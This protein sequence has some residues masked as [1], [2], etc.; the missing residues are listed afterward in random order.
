MKLKGI[1]TFERNAD[2]ILLGVVSVAALGALALQFL[3]GS[4]TIKVGG[5][6]TPLGAAFAPVSA[7]AQDLQVKVNAESPTFPEAPAFSLSDKLA[8]GA[9]APAYTPRRVALGPAPLITRGDTSAAMAASAYALP[10]VPAPS[11][12]LAMAYTATIHPA[13][14]LQNP[15]LGTLLPDVQPFDKP[16]VSIECALD[17]SALRAALESDPEGPAEP[18]P[19]GWWRDPSGLGA[20]LVAIVALEVERELLASPD[21]M[22]PEG[23]TTSMVQ[24]MPGRINGLKLWQDG[25]RSI[26]DVPITIDTLRAAAAEVQRPDYYTVIEGPEWESPS[27]ALGRGDPAERLKQV[28]LGRTQFDRAQRQL[29]DMQER[30]AAAPAGDSD[31][32]RERE[33]TGVPGGGKGGSGR[34]PGGP[35][36][37]AA[38]APA[39]GDRRVI[40]RNIAR[41]RAELDAA[42]RKLIALGEEVPG[43]QAPADDA[44]ALD[45]G[46]P[47]SML[48]DPALTLWAHDLTGFPGATYRYRT[49]IVI[50]NPLFDRNL[51]EGPQKE[52][53]KESLLRGEWSQWS[54]PVTVDPIHAFFV[55]SAEDRSQ[56][57]PRPQATAEI[58]Q[59]Y[60]GYYRVAQVA[61]EPGDVVMREAKLPELRVAD[62]TKL[63]ATLR[64][65]NPDL[66]VPA[67]PLPGPAAPS[68]GK[69]GPGMAPSAP[70]PR[71]P[72][73]PVPG[74]ETAADGAVTWPAWMSVE[75]PRTMPLVVDAVL[76]DV[77]SVPGEEAGRARTQAVLRLG[78]GTLA[79]KVPDTDRGSDLYKRL[80]ASAKVGVNQ[81]RET[82]RPDRNSLPIRPERREQT[83]PG[84][85]GGGG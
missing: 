85:G 63:E 8:I 29:A 26:G 34:R 36:A 50:N 13:E 39:G 15:E 73:D 28:R 65:G 23:P 19:L 60:Y 22:T 61:L 44:A 33:Q 66:G 49:R 18:L 75:L 80:D 55:T 32:R 2:R 67:A 62:M 20:D 46:S 64:S 3:G 35:A 51:Q 24:P 81:G 6:D 17:G 54:T 48:D 79:V 45:S 43:Y 40:E 5:K 76:L 56:I 84:G 37:P 10:Q 57:N 42:A 21:G 1:N 47:A 52:L 78:G 27:T 16:M 74:S 77:A 68:P 41:V 11:A 53:G 4:T 12:V 9:S 83:A 14:R 25:V 59:M 38:S 72:R 58:Y 82:L 31:S 30:L 71:G 7:A 70:N 69:G